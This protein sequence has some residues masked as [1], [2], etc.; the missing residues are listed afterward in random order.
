M[1]TGLTAS[2]ASTGEILELYP[3][4][5]EADIRAALAYATWRAEEYD[6]PLAQ[7]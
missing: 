4:L 5:D 3:Y 6:M 7:A 2:G 1:I